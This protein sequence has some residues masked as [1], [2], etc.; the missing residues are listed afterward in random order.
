VAA[1]DTPAA[2]RSRFIKA[3][4]LFASPPPRDLSIPFARRVQRGQL[5]YVAVFDSLPE[6]R[7]HEI[8]QQVGA[9]QCALQHVSLDD[10]FVEL[11]QRK[12]PS[13]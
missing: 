1:C 4:F 11:V 10:V 2:L 8:A 12:E 3:S 6:D 5:E 7:I 9:A 13:L